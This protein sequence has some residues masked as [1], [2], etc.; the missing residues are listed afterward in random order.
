MQLQE[1]EE[2]SYYYYKRLRKENFRKDYWPRLKYIEKMA[3]RT[4]FDY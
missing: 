1:K 2:K 4:G 3:R